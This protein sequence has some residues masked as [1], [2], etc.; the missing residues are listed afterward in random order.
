MSA[1]PTIRG[2]QRLLVRSERLKEKNDNDSLPV[3][4]E[5]LNRQ[6]GGLIAPPALIT[7]DL[8]REFAARIKSLE[9]F[10]SPEAP[11]RRSTRPSQHVVTEDFDVAKDRARQSGVL[12]DCLELTGLLK[13]NVLRISDVAKDDAVVLDDVHGSMDRA[14]DHSEATT[15]QLGVVG[16]ERLGF[17]TPYKWLAMVVAAYLIVNFIFL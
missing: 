15:S 7:P 17:F 11:V 6:F 14:K 8:Q 9:S 10:L 3:N 16:E 1:R 12:D 5:E 2:F 4:L 13:A